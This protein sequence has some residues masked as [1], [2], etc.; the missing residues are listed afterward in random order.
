MHDVYLKIRIAEWFVFV[1]QCLSLVGPH[2]HLLPQPLLLDDPVG[3]HGDQSD[4]PL[5]V[6]QE[7]RLVVVT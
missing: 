5:L 4:E 3:H 1:H 6:D 2:Q 7:G